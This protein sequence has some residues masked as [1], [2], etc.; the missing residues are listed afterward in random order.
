MHRFQ[1]VYERDLSLWQLVVSEVTAQKILTENMALRPIELAR[2]VTNHPMMQAASEHL[3]RAA[4]DEEQPL[5]F[6]IPVGV[7]DLERA[8]FASRVWFHMANA[9]LNGDAELLGKLE[10]TCRQLFVYHNAWFECMRRYQEHKKS[11][12]R[13]LTAM[14]V[15]MH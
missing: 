9:E 13:I 5:L 8:V 6:R 11:K 12:D 4:F 7:N 1:T 3:L 15:Q 10:Q 14:Q 2:A